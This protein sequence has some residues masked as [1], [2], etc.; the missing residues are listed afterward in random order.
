MLK[1]RLPTSI[2]LVFITCLLSSCAFGPNVIGRWQQVDGEDTLEFHE[3]GTFTAVDNMGATVVGRYT[4]HADG[5]LYYAVTHSD[6]QKAQ[7]RP[8]DTLAVRIAG[9]KLRPFGNELVISTEDS[10]QPEIYQR[11]EWF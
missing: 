3:D 1:Y 7:L 8:V 10:T 9:V 2:I 6:M 4:L 11:A 5:T